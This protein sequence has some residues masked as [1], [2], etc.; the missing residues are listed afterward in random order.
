M[1]EP[2]LEMDD[3]ATF[4]PGERFA[5]TEILERPQQD[6]EQ[7][8]TAALP[9]NGSSLSNS[10]RQSSVNGRW[11]RQ[12]ERLDGRTEGI[13]LGGSSSLPRLRGIEG[14][15]IPRRPF[16]TP[17]FHNS[18][19]GILRVWMLRRVSGSTPIACPPKAP[20]K[21][22]VSASSGDRITRPDLRSRA[23]QRTSRGGCLADG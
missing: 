18:R 2:P 22:S 20:A 11:L 9:R 7:G 21:S 10:T 23:A 4:G 15:A 8:L 17:M 13:T 12:G 5:K 3:F 6:S 1:A 16:G 19:V 14:E